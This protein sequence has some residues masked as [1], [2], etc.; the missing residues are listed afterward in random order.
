MSTLHTHP[1]SS[2]QPAAGSSAATDGVDPSA[3]GNPSASR[4]A[5]AAAAAAAAAV[6][7]NGSVLHADYSRGYGAMAPG[8]HGQMLPPPTQLHSQHQQQQ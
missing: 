6:A 7:S 4:D 8:G 2:A 1:Y 3:I 5:V